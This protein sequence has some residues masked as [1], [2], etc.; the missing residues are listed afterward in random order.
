MI[1]YSTQFTWNE[2]NKQLFRVL[3]KKQ[4][5]IKKRKNKKRKE[6]NK[7][8]RPRDQPESGIRSRAKNEY[9][10]VLFRAQLIIPAAYVRI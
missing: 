7:K 5:K 6:Q 9:K 8:N 1:Q 10:L 4:K 2:N 3:K